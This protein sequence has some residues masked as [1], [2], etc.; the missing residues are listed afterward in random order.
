MTW[1]VSCFTRMLTSHVR[2]CNCA[3]CARHNVRTSFPH[4]VAYSVP[5]ESDALIHGPCDIE[6]HF[7]INDAE[8]DSPSHSLVQ[9][10]PQPAQ[11][12]SRSKAKKWA[13]TP[14][15]VDTD[16]MNAVQALIKR[17]LESV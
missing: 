8:G 12:P 3:T 9:A 11:K 5:L 14:L 13:S 7:S 1:H 2:N 4:A 16:D 17:E 6:P 15:G 10:A